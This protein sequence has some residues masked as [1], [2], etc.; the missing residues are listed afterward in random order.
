[1]KKSIKYVGA[2]VIVGAATFGTIKL[3]KNWDK[4]KAYYKDMWNKGNETGE[5]EIELPPAPQPKP[6]PQ[7][8]PEKKNNTQVESEPESE[9][10]AGDYSQPIIRREILEGKEKI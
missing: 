9:Q 6:A 5:N 8:A 1:M 3:V 10:Q 2:G 7:P 4:V